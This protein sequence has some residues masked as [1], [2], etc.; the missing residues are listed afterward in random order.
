[1]FVVIERKIN[2]LSKI[3]DVNYRYTC[4]RG[5]VVWAILKQIPDTVL[6]FVLTFCK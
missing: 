5:L 6:W 3:N 2:W 4:Q 1:M